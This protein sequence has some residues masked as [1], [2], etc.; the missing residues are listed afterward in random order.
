MRERFMLQMEFFKPINQRVSAFTAA[1]A[2]ILGGGCAASIEGEAASAPRST[3]SRPVVSL[4]GDRL[5]PLVLSVEARQTAAENLAQARREVEANPT[6]E[7]AIIWL[8]RR[9]AYLGE[10]YEAIE[11]FSDG[12]KQYPNSYYLLRHRGHRYIT[13]RQIELAIDDFERA[14]QLAK[15]KPDEVEPDGAPN[16][17]N[18]PTSTIQTNIWYHLGLAHYLNGDFAKAVTA[19]QMCL[20]WCRNDDIRVATL[21]WLYISAMRA[22]DETLAAQ[23]LQLAGKDMKLLENEDYYSLLRLFRGEVAESE[24]LQEAAP[25]SVKGRVDASREPDSIPNLA[26][27]T[28]AY[29]IAMHHHFNGDQQTAETMFKNILAT[30]FWPAFGYIAAEA[31]LARL[32]QANE[33]RP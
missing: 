16:Q 3:Q 14:A 32:K 17:Y 18:I 13:T 20:K 12:L 23:S 22:G 25:E 7:R 31:E 1:L 24:L 33:P 27:T 10:Y 2:V 6:D 9:L 29:G 5:P 30:G 28:L 19:Y 11:V 15:E 4:R 26:D 21:Y 8:G